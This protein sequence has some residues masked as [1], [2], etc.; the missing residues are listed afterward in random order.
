MSCSVLDSAHI[1]GKKWSLPILEEIAF[2]NFHSF[3][4]FIRK[5]RSITPRVLSNQLKELETAG[6]IKKDVSSSTTSYTLTPKGSE[7]HKLIKKMKKWNVKWNTVPAYCLQI[8]CTSCP[9]F[10]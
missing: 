7:F 10:R 9:N 8:P 6:L 1:I 2:G 4:T 3:N 5:S